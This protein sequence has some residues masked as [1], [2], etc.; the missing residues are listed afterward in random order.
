MA[1]HVHSHV[2]HSD[3]NHAE[4]GSL[5]DEC[6][7]GV[8]GTYTISLH[9]L[10]IAIIF[11]ASVLGTGSP[12]LS[13][14]FRFFQIS[15]NWMRTLKAFGSGVILATAYVHMFLE[16][17]E[18]LTNPCLPTFFTETYPA[19]APV[20]ALFATLAM[21]MLDYHTFAWMSK[22]VRISKKLG[23][24]YDH[25][26]ACCGGNPLVVSMGSP[27]WQ[28]KKLSLYLLE[29][30]I[31][32]HSVIIGIA[33]GMANDQAFMSLL[34][35]IAF[36]Q[37]FEGFALGA[38]LISI[39]LPRSTTTFF[40]LLFS[41]TTSIGCVIGVLLTVFATPNPNSVVS[42]L[43]QGIMDSLGAG[44]LIYTAIVE[45]LMPDFRDEAFLKVP[46]FWRTMSLVAV[47]MGALSMSIIGAW[48]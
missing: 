22:N 33:L 38:L 32:I 3:H 35:A 8:G 36:H 2:D 5:M 45:V 4:G 9:T 13:T 48:A 23:M 41:L 28:K 30:S 47:W 24:D 6:S 19:L 21:H 42:L 37:F 46:K 39:E 15:P 26:D 14:R 27:E 10:G 7:A 16:A 1:P 12:V 25:K 17:I 43:A 31:A 20:L 44:I 34:I 11:F 29:F 18:S 40:V